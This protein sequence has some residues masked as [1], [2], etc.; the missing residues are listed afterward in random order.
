MTDRERLLAA[1]LD[2][3]ADDT[4]RLV[5]SDHLQDHDEPALGRFIRAGVIAARFRDLDGT[6][7]PDYSAA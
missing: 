1:V 2:S 3:P 4:A 5:L 7:D 6:P